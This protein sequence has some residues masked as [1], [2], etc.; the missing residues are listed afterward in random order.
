MSK[1]FKAPNYT[2]VPHVVLREW[3]KDLGEAKLKVLLIAID[4]TLGWGQYEAKL[5]QEYL[6]ERAGMSRRAIAP[7]LKELVQE[8]VLEA[9]SS[10]EYVLNFEGDEKTSPTKWEKTSHT[11]GKKLPIL[12]Y[13]K[14]SIKETTNISK[15]ILD[16]ERMLTFRQRVLSRL[17][18]PSC[19]NEGDRKTPLHQIQMGYLNKLWI[20]LFGN[21]NVPEYGVLAQ[22]VKLYGGFTGNGPHRLAVEMLKLSGDEIA[23]GPQQLLLDKGYKNKKGKQAEEAIT[24]FTATARVIRA[25]NDE[26]EL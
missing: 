20:F 5:T 16:T 3:L 11:N 4:D 6:A 13:N 22:L 8:G 19:T 23:G 12:L 18:N 10:A 1:R 26:M 7:A 2:Q 24:D 25:D 9:F 15:D 21:S 14:E 17:S